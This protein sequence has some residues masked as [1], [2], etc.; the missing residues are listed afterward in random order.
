MYLN[1]QSKKV[2]LLST[3]DYNFLLGRI[4]LQVMTELKTHLLINQHL[5]LE[6]KKDKGID[7][8]LSWKSNGVHNS[9]LKP[10]HTAFLHSVKLSGYSMR[11]KFDKDPLAIEQ[12]DYLTKIVNVYLLY[13]LN[14][15]PK[16]PINNF[17]FKNCLFGVTNIVKNSDKEKYV[18]SGYGITFDSG[19]FW[20]FDNDTASSSS[21]SF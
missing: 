1:E 11:I 21:H 8:G 3:T 17:K 5:I 2:K 7:Y 12:K 18:C 19:G 4:F 14:N 20:S 6:L 15:W 10:L 9:K 16:D 13:D